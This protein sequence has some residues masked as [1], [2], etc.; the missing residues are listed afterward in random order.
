MAT[1]EISIGP[2]GCVPDSTGSVYF[3]PLDVC[4]GITNDVF[5]HIVAVF[6][7]VVD[8][9]LY[10]RFVV[11]QNYV[12]TPVFKFAW[13]SDNGVNTGNVV[14]G[15]AYRT[16][17]GDDTTSL[18][19]ATAEESLTVTDAA[20]GTDNFRLIPTVAAAANFAA[21][22]TVQFIISRTPTSGSD[23]MAARVLLVDMIFQYAD[24]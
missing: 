24:A 5:K 14:L 3:Q 4:T 11:P 9:K 1:H 19:Q 22:E 21:G 2:D 7:D 18:D 12:G 6:D 17:G 10:G 15:L 8:T 16:V 13:T 23:T 20:P